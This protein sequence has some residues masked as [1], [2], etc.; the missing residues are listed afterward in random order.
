MNSGGGGKSTSTTINYDPAEVPYRK[1]TME[2]AQRIYNNNAEQMSTGGYPGSKPVGQS[3][4]TL[5]AQQMAIQNA[6]GAQNQVSGMQ[7]AVN[8]GL[9]QAQ[10]PA[11]NPYLQN[12]IT[13]AVRPIT[14]SYT[15]S[16]GVMS[17]IRD[18]AG[19]AGQYGSSRQGIAEG[20]AAGRY[21]DA[22]GDTSAKL[23]YD[24]YEKGLD[25]FAK[26]LAFAPEAMNAGM[27]PSTWL[28]GVG[29]QQENYQQELENYQAA[30]RE[31]G[32]NAPWLPVQ[33]LAQI[34]LGLNPT[35]TTTTTSGGNRT[36]LGQVAGTAAS[37]GS[38]YSMLSA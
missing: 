13:A 29:A 10:D 12:A 20:L 25:T 3:D 9:T 32:L 11:N 2:E 34:V 18:G 7:N 31:W 22:V 4:A 26:T 28:S 6:Y 19:M 33:N 5:A 30:S 24:A 36:S 14:E 37:L 21:A 27:T 23:S 1:F 8:W 38:L 15:D 35:G 17:Q 16:G